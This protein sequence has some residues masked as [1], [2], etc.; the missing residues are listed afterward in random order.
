MSVA[1]IDETLVARSDA[2]LDIEDRAVQFAESAYE[3]ILCAGRRMVDAEPHLARLQRSL[4][5]I[6]LPYPAERLARLRAG[7]A[8]L[9]ERM[10]QGDGM[11]YLQVTGGS[12]E[13]TLAPASRPRP[14]SIAYCRA[15]PVPVSADEIRQISVT[16]MPDLRWGRCDIKSTALLANAMLRSAAQRQGYDD[17]FLHDSRGLITEASAANAW[18]IRGGR[19]HTHPIGPKILAGITRERLIDL[20]RRSGVEVEETGF[21]EEELRTADEAFIT[22]A[23]ALVTAV[24]RVNHRPVGRGDIGPTTRRLFAAYLEYIHR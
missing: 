14:T 16:L 20:A 18:I 1:L 17:V 5:E 23:T 2:R 13:R 7:L 24:T 15:M 11:V 19:V 6:G 10:P 22:S 9:V 21:S 12:G 8:L 3:V 4:H